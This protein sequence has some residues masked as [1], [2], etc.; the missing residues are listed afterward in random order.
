MSALHEITEVEVHRSC[1]FFSVDHG[2][3]KCQGEGRGEKEI[4]A[5]LHLEV[6]VWLGA[7]AGMP[8]EPDTLSPLHPISSS[9]R[10]APRYQVCQEA[11]FRLCMPDHD[12]VAPKVIG[13]P[14][15]PASA[16]PDR[17]AD[18]VA[19]VRHDS[20]CGRKDRLTV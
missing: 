2:V 5:V 9:Q 7:M 18:T 1:L 15:H 13:T 3:G 17:I 4:P 6:Q 10:D 20:I 8:A 11:V 14:I 12:K 16:N 19:E